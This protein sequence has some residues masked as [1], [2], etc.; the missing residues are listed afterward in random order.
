MKVCINCK[1]SFTCLNNWY[2]Y[3]DGYICQY[4]YYKLKKNGLLKK[5]S[6]NEEFWSKVDKKGEDECWEWK[7]GKFI[8]GYGAYC[9]NCKTVK[10]HRVSYEITYGSIPKNM[11]VLHKCDNPSCCNPKHLFLGTNKDNTED[12]F[13]KKRDGLG[14]QKGS[15]NNHSKLSEEQVK[16]IRFMYRTKLATQYQLSDIFGVSNRNI[17]R[18]VNGKLWNHI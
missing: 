17:S 14:N 4:C 9:R 13:I 2:K 1:N 8:Q 6:K 16:K 11:C 10:S 12:M 18:I 3:M 7:G 5:R 15:N